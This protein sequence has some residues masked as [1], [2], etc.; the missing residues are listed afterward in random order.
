MNIFVNCNWVDIR[1]QQYSK[2]LPTNNTQNN[3]VNNL[4]GKSVGR[5][6]TLRVKDVIL[7]L[8]SHE[9]VSATHV[10]IFRVVRTRMSS[11]LYRLYHCSPIWIINH[12]IQSGPKKCIHSLLI[13]IFGISYDSVWM[14]MVATSNTYIESKIQGHLS[15]QFCFCIRLQS[16]I[17]HVKVCIH[18]FGVLCI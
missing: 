11:S 15:Y 9:H 12:H 18:F 4:I 17:F 1:W 3:T 14:P 16:N 5:A 7:L 13:S 10:A 8:S 6:P 2:H